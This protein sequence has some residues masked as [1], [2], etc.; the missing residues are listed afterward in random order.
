[1]RKQSILVRFPDRGGTVGW[2]GVRWAGGRSA[3]TVP[4]AGPGGS[5]QG[6]AL[7]TN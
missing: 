5:R 7:T 2:G 3:R 1:V 4:K 6:I